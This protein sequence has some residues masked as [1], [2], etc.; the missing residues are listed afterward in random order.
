M[1]GIITFALFVSV[2]VP[3]AA[4]DTATDTAAGQNA[5]PEKATG[6]PVVTGIWETER[7]VVQE[8]EGSRTSSKSVFVFLA[9]E[10]SIE[11]TQFAD[12]E[13]ARPAMKAF[14]SGSYTITQ[15]SPSVAGAYDATFG[16]SYK[17]L[18]LYDEALL[19][20]VNRGAC[21][22]R[23]WR[24]GEPQDVSATGCLWVVPVSACTQE[25]DLVKLTGQQLFLGERPKPGQDICAESRRARTLRSL[26]LVRR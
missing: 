2:A 21:G 4:S 17:A 26:A 8:R 25:F 22:A 6:A 23:T 10:W 14:F 13:C 7:C 3:G 24:R 1:F 9:R 12:G 19:A 5:T 15:P 16:F 11:V 18:T 20:Q